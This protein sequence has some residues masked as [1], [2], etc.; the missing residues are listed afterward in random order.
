[1]GE[2]PVP[3]HDGNICQINIQ[4]KNIMLQSQIVNNHTTTSLSV[5]LSH[6]VCS[7]RRARGVPSGTGRSFFKSLR[8]VVGVGTW[9][10]SLVLEHLDKSVEEN[11]DDSSEARSDPIDPCHRLVPAQK[12]KGW[13]T[14][15]GN[16]RIGRAQRL[17]RTNEPG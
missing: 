11:C 12:S 8:I 6:P 2:Q 7:N 9:I 1:M 15:S 16:C 17:G 14:Y 10:G 4:P 13:R 5:H 3:D